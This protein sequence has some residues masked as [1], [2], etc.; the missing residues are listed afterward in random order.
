MRYRKRTTIEALQWD[1]DMAKM[2]EYL[3][4]AIPMSN[5]G[6]L[7]LKSG[8]LRIDTLEGS[9]WCDL[10]NW[11]AKGE[12]NEVYPIRDDLFKRIYEVVE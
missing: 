3:Q 11:V 7:R 9:V 1:G 4:D 8:S 10:G 12:I 2:L 6:T 5:R